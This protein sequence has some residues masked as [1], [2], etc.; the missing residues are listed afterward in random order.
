[1]TEYEDI[2]RIL[3]N[4]VKKDGLRPVARSLE[5]SPSFLNQVLRR[6]SPLSDN[7]ARALGYEKIVKYRK[8][9]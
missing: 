9:K 6:I 1:M 2:V 7:L 4:R 8:V 5:F 3:E